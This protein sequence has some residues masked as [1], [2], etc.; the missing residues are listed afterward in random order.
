V[1]RK[2]FWILFKYG[3]GVGLLA[4]V[5]WQFWSYPA[6]PPEPDAAATIVGVG[7]N[8][9]SAG[10]LGTTATYLATNPGKTLGLVNAIGKPINWVPF[11]LALIICM[12]A[13]L[14]TFVRWYILVRA[15]D[16]PFT[17]G[18][19]L[20]LGMIGYYLSAFLPGSVGGDIIKATFIAREQSRRTVAVATVLIDRAIGLCGLF[21]LVALVGGFFWKAGY[22]E[23][24]VRNEA[25]AV[26]LEFIV[27]VA[28]GFLLASLAFWLLLGVLPQ[29]RADKFAWRLSR[30]PRIGHSL[31]EFWRAVWMYRCRGR[32]VG[33]AILLAMIGH[34]GFVLTFYFAA[35]TLHQATEVPT[36]ATH[37]LIVPVGMA[38]QAGCPTPSGVGGGEVGYGELYRRVDYDFDKGVLGSLTKRVVE[39]ILGLVGYL[40]YLRMKPALRAASPLRFKE[41][42]GAEGVPAVDPN[43]GN[44][45]LA[46]PGDIPGRP[47]IAGEG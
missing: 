1:K 23:T 26:F 25:A 10:P 35:L 12:T 39:W 27:S 43:L 45:P 9:S 22:L 37:F 34:V 30:I 31:A 21:W 41:G 18:N 29:R 44:G 42:T 2:L 47:M 24:I 6:P 40:V 7:A 4:W 33:V 20:R 28:L 8:P 15:Q 38:I 11:G 5:I 46:Q 3:L 36:L 14:I 17:L 32:A 16:L 19:A 13:V